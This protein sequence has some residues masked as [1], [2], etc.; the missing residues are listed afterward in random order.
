MLRVRHAL[1][2]DLLLE[3]D[4]QELAGEVEKLKQLLEPRPGQGTK[5]MRSKKSER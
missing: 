5:Q 1:R 4:P 3:V 2:G